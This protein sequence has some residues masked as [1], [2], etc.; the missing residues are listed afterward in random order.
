MRKLSAF[1]YSDLG[2]FT[3]DWSKQDYCLNWIWL[4]LGMEV[5]KH[6]FSSG[7]WLIMNLGGDS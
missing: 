4:C 5:Y 3:L 1:I 7:V 6:S 2:F